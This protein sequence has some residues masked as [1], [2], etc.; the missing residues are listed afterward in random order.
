MALTAVDHPVNHIEPEPILI[1]DPSE[2]YRPEIKKME[3]FR[4]YSD[5]K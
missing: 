1:L 4:E 3:D 5:V 2:L